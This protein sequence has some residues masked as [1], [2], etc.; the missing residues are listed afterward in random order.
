MNA[1]TSSVPNSIKLQIKEMV[2]V[3]LL[4]NINFD[5]K[6]INQQGQN[7]A[8]SDMFEWF[9]KFLCAEKMAFCCSLKNNMH[10]NEPYYT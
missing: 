7:T 3:K 8:Q 4:F 2:T 1:V 10:L 9:S 5:S 6:V